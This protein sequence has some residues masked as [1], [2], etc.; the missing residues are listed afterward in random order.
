MDNETEM[1]KCSRNLLKFLYI[2]NL[3][4]LCQKTIATF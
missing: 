4:Y 2:H 1:H 3:K